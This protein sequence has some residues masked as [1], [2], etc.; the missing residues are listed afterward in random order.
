MTDLINKR[1]R[2]KEFNKPPDDFID[3]LRFS[4]LQA[5]LS[6]H[7]NSFIVTN[8][9]EIIFAD[10]ERYRMITLRE[11][12]GI[13][14]FEWFEIINEEPIKINIAIKDIQNILEEN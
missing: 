5:F 14:D 7:E 3:Q 9:N 10:N 6:N 13:F 8:A 2:L 4:R 12:R 11:I 1:V